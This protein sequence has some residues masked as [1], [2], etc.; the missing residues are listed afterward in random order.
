MGGGDGLL[1]PSPEPLGSDAIS[2]E[3]VSACSEIVGHRA[4]VAELFGGTGRTCWNLECKH[5]N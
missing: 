1:G 5:V 2:M 3:I 4:V